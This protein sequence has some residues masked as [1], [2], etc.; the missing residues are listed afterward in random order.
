MSTMRRAV[1]VAGTIGCAAI[2]FGCSR[3]AARGSAD[4][5][6]GRPTTS[7]ILPRTAP[8]LP[9]HLTMT[10][11]GDRVAFGRIGSIAADSGGTL[12][13]GDELAQQIL[14]FDSSGGLLRTL[15]GK[16]NGPGEFRSLG[17]IAWTG[18][19]LAALDRSNRRVTYFGAERG[20]VS[21]RRWPADA[22]RPFRLYGAGRTVYAAAKYPRSRQM[23]SSAA[24]AA[25]VFRQP[26]VR[27]FAITRDSAA[28]PFLAV[29]DT[30]A[31]R[32]AFDCDGAD[33]TIV[34]FPEPLF[35]RDGPLSRLPESARDGRGVAYRVSRRSDRPRIRRHDR[36][37]RAGIR[38]P[39]RDG[40]GMGAGFARDPRA[41]A[42]G[43][44]A[45]LRP[46]GHAPGVPP[47]D[48]LD[49]RR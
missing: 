30:V 9:L 17:S 45:G 22:G 7:D 28:H 18:D 4:E 23:F 13:V 32:Q 10:L 33:H 35:G 43:G 47:R 29:E 39:A 26:G 21:T 41:G 3:D 46:G 27:Y 49:N 1:A 15:G 48:P 34:T 44:P 36:R 8:A 24:E 37:D 16:G 40:R 2:L 31:E 14:V 25:R 42:R 5:G 19:A 12:Y 20:D 38:A 6:A 11:P